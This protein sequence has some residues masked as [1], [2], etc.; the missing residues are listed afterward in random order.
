[1]SNCSSGAL[2]ISRV[3]EVN[4]WSFSAKVPRLGTT[5]VLEKWMCWVF[6]NKVGSHGRGAWLLEL[7]MQIRYVC[8]SSSGSSFI[9]WQFLPLCPSPFWDFSMSTTLLLRFTLGFQFPAPLQMHF[10]H[11]YF[12]NLGKTWGRNTEEGI[13][14]WGKSKT[15]LEK[16]LKKISAEY[17]CNRSLCKGSFNIGG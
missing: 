9:P 17:I 1:M 7:L 3:T 6:S 4:P 8:T 14:G 15:T 5:M 11:V 10:T 2:S 12:R 13:L 16:L